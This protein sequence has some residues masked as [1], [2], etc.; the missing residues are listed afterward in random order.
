[1]IREDDL[2]FC[3]RRETEERAAA[4]SAI[5]PTVKSIHLDM[6]DRYADR[7]WGLEKDRHLEETARKSG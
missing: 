7:A 1:V 6:A 3:A 2:D 5:D 4:A